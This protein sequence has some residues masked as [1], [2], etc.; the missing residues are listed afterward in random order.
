[1]W[2]GMRFRRWA[3]NRSGDCC[4]VIDEVS[5]TSK[6]SFRKSLSYSIHDFSLHTSKYM[7]NCCVAVVVDELSEVKDGSS[8]SHLFDVRPVT[9]VIAYDI[10]GVT[11]YVS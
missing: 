9:S 10:K 1:M 7:W 11:F 5:C 4:Y 8:T 2:E 6:R 3:E